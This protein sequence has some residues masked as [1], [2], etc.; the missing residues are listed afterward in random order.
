MQYTDDLT[1]YITDAIEMVSPWNLSDEEFVE[2]IHQQAQL[3]A[4]IEGY[5]QDDP[6]DHFLQQATQLPL[7][8]H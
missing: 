5:F 4:G 2:A 1:Q 3:M 6:N 7:D 8:L